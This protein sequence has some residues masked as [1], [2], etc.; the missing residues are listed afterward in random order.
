M[1][2][3]LYLFIIYL[4][5]L[6]GSYFF[7]RLIVKVRALWAVILTIAYLVLIDLWIE[8]FNQIHYYLRDRGIY[9]ELGH[10][11]LELLLLCGFC[12]INALILIFFILYKRSRY[13]AKNPKS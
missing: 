4:G 6:T 2:D 3:L 1:N 7:Y 13:F 11:S 5:F 12:Y 8:L 10:A 9:I